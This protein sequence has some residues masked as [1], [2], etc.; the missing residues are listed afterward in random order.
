MKYLISD[1]NEQALNSPEKFVR[2]CEENY[3]ERIE[4]AADMIMKNMTSCPIVLLSGPSGAGKTT[5]SRKIEDEL[6]KRGINCYTVS[7]DN[8]FNTLN[9]ETC[10]RTE[11]GEVDFES[12]LML[13]M[14]LLNEHF[15]KLAAGEEIHVP[16]YMFTR[17]KRSASQFTK[18][19][20]EDNEIAIFE[21][22]HALNDTITDKNPGAFGL[23]ISAEAEFLADD[24]SVFKPE[25]TRLCR[26]V[27]RDN[28]YR[29]ADAKYTLKLW[30][31]VMRGEREHITPFIGKASLRLDS[32][33]GYEIS[34]LRDCALPLLD[35]VEEGMPGHDEICHLVP[36][37]SQFAGME[38]SLVPLD[39]LLREFIGGGI[40]EY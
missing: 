33:I 26:R 38:S 25:W 16:Y 14:E 40:Y 15:K 19:H 1:I 20:L 24:G 29:G 36:V 6:K 34:V 10:P 5:T 11:E 13:D 22:I 39:S 12:P 37:L 23:Y 2:D 8:Y 18:M 32:S 9:L 28:N 3:M 4:L 21:G 27:V 17:Q 30:E 31:N 7:M 35:E